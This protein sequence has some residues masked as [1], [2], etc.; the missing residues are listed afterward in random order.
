MIDRS[1]CIFGNE[2]S[3]KTYKKACQS[4]EKYIK[5]FGDDRDKEYY[6]SLKKNYYL[7]K[8]IKIWKQK[9]L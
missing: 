5:K 1:R 6:V 4:K 2:I 9:K 8:K 7:I 3:E